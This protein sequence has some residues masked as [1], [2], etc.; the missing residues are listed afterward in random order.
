MR[1]CLDSLLH[2]SPRAERCGCLPPAGR[3]Q[4]TAAQPP[5]PL[6]RSLSLPAAGEASGEATLRPTG[7]YEYQ[8]DASALAIYKPQSLAGRKTSRRR[9]DLLQVIS[10]PESTEAGGK[11]RSACSAVRPEE[12][13]QVHPRRRRMAVVL[14]HHAARV[15]PRGGAGE[16]RLTHDEHVRFREVRPRCQRVAVELHRHSAGAE[17]VE[18]GGVVPA[19]E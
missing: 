9:K 7:T 15:E 16:R 8:Y 13:L 6:R 11:R 10:R 17:Q 18:G 1:R 14:V 19:L 12:R 2:L 4:M 3:V 5:P